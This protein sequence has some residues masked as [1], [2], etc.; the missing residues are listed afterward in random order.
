MKKTTLFLLSLSTIIVFFTACP[1]SISFPL[2]AVGSNKIDKKIIGTWVCDSCDVLKKV[3]VTKGSDENS[4]AIEIIESGS[5]YT[6]SQKKFTG[7]VTEIDEK[8]FLYNRA[9]GT[10][11]FYTYCYELSDKN[12]LVLYD[13]SLL[14]GGVDAVKSVQSYRDQVSSSMKKS[15][16][17]SGKQT[18]KKQ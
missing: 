13:I 12:T 16:F 6:L 14:D 5:S 3:L 4:Y 9:E 7:Y 8:K 1:V 17:L 15:G 10:T 18:L 11:S 2:D